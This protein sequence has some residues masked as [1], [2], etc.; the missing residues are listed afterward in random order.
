MASYKAHHK[1]VRRKNVQMKPLVTVLRWWNR[2][3]KS[4]EKNRL[5]LYEPLLLTGLTHISIKRQYIVVH[6]LGRCISHPFHF[7]HERTTG[8]SCNNHIMDLD[9]SLKLLYYI[10]NRS[11]INKWVFAGVFFSFFSKIVYLKLMHHLIQ[12]MWHRTVPIGKLAEGH[13][14]DVNTLSIKNKLK[15]ILIW[16]I[17]GEFF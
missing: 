12:T 1:I 13:P 8:R 3:P 9:H 5:A 7:M 16:K 4:V 15:Y 11:I 17:T 10:W 2:T 6:D 14:E